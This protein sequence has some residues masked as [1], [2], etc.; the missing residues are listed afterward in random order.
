MLQLKLT[1]YGPKL[2]P[3]SLLASAGSTSCESCTLYHSLGLALGNYSDPTKLTRAGSHAASQPPQ[4]PLGRT[5]SPFQA[6]TWKPSYARDQS[7]GIRGGLSAKSTGIRP[8]ASPLSHVPVKEA[9]LKLSFGTRKRVAYHPG[10]TTRTTHDESQE[11]AVE[12]KRT[13]YGCLE[14]LPPVS[15]RDI[16]N[17]TRLV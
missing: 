17:Q 7:G 10:Q 1:P 12:R 5:F 2:P 13:F 6:P 16:R 15:E 11:V 14:T 4:Y 8:M 3:S 9:M